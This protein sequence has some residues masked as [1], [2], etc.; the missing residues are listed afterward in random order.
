MVAVDGGHT[1]VKIFN[2]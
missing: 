1:A 2:D